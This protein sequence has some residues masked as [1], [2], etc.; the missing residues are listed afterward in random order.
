[1]RV[2][3]NVPVIT[4]GSRFPS[5]I[6]NHHG[7]DSHTILRCLYHFWN[8]K[9]PRVLRKWEIF[10]FLKM[11][12]YCVRMQKL[13]IFFYL[14]RGWPQNIMTS[15]I[16]SAINQRKRSLTY[17]KTSSRKSSFYWFLYFVTVLSKVV[18]KS[19]H[20]V[21]KSSHF[22]IKSSHFVIKLLHFVITIASW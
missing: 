19:S 9:N 5:R 14:N 4:I 7:G 15:W 10:D 3:P 16:V 20:F 11:I 13:I 1:M 21:I 8:N 6:R 17:I 12:T 22:V 2:T 18:I